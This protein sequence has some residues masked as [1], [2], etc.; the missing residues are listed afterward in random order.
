MRSYPNKNPQSAARIITLALLA[1]GSLSKAEFN[2]LDRLGTHEQL[3]IQSEELQ[4]AMHTACE[5]LLSAAHL[6]RAD[7]CE[8]DPRMLCELIAEID[9]PELRHKMLRLC[10]AAVK[11]VDQWVLYREMLRTQPSLWGVE[12]V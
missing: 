3:G 10:V 6:R 5:D 7:S 2:V 9:D 4:I 12:R 11:A 1:D 8:V